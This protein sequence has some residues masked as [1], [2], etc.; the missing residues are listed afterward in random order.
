MRKNIPKGE[1]ISKVEFN[2]EFELTA[3]IVE[4]SLHIVQKK[5]GHIDQAYSLLN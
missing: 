4:Y 1:S 3:L 2:D 5:P